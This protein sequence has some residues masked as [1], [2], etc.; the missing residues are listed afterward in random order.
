MDPSSTKVRERAVKM[1]VEER[2]LFQHEEKS[3]NRV[4]EE[5]KTDQ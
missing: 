3:F 5:Y 2:C 1:L 4:I